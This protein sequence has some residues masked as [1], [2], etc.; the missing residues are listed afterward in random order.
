MAVVAVIVAVYV[1]VAAI[2]IASRLHEQI[3]GTLLA[4]DGFKSMNTPEE[5]RGTLF[6]IEGHRWKR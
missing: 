3:R 6:V 2:E 4:T 5:R 1:V